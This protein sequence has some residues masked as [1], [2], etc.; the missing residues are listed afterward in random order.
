MRVQNRR[1][2]AFTLIELVTASVLM[3]IILLGIY[4]V[5]KQSMAVEEQITKRWHTKA[6]AQQIADLLADSIENIVNVQGTSPLSAGKDEDF[7]GRQL[8]CTVMGGDA[9]EANPANSA[10]QWRRYRW[11]LNED[12]AGQLL[13]QT[14]YFAGTIELLPVHVD[15]ETTQDQL[16]NRVPLEVIAE[17][18]KSINIHFRPKYNPDAEWKDKWGGIGTPIL[19]RIKVAVGDTTV[20]RY[21]S[22]H[23]TL[24]VSS[25]EGGG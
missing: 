3:G 1:Q 20:T 17:D 13:I 14:R 7:G 23:V 15:E 11:G 12:Q 6:A 18:L 5:F 24:A 19:V 9:T 22:P 8:S 2:D 4:T 25:A 21:V 16:W 10:M